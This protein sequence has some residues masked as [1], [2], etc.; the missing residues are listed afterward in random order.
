M[1]QIIYSS[2]QEWT[3]NKTKAYECIKETVT[4]YVTIGAISVGDWICHL[5]DGLLKALQILTK[6]ENTNN[7]TECISGQICIG[8][9]TTYDSFEDH[10]N[11]N[12]NTLVNKIYKNIITQL[13]TYYF[14]DNREINILYECKTCKSME[15]VYYSSFNDKHQCFDCLPPEYR[16]SS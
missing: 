9:Q 2:F 10:L 3:A 4:D 14:D 7:S 12:D 8:I 5:Y 6:D 15:S 16:M 1:V 11:I 13:E